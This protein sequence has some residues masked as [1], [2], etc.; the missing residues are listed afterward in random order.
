MI[1]S[2]VWETLGQAELE[3]VNAP[4]VNPRAMF[5]VPISPRDESYAVEALTARSVILK[6]RDGL[7]K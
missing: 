4:V 2:Q 7:G 6:R 3:I 1:L 5:P